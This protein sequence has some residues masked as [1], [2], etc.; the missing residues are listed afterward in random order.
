MQSIVDL[1]LR[2]YDVNRDQVLSFSEFL[3]WHARDNAIF[4]WIH[5]FDLFPPDQEEMASIEESIRP[6]PSPSS[7]RENL[8]SRFNG[9]AFAVCRP[10]ENDIVQYVDDRHQIRLSAQKL[11]LLK[12]IA[13]ESGF[14][15]IDPASLLNVSI[16]CCQKESNT[17]S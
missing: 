1:N 4:Q 14:R 8:R 11:A 5:I 16:C 6:A 7:K 9:G 15:A 12:S 2:Q 10:A 3:T 17:E 13:E